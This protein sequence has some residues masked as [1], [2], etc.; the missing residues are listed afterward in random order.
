MNPIVLGTFGW[1]NENVFGNVIVVEVGGWSS[2]LGTVII[3]LII[4]FV[5]GA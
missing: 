5:N 2:W 1:E 3:D 4:R